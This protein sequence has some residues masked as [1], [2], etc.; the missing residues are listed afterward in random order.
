MEIKSDI[1]GV[2]IFLVLLEVIEFLPKGPRALKY[3]LAIS[4]VLGEWIFDAAKTKALKTTGRRSYA[5]IRGDAG[6]NLVNSAA[7]LKNRSCILAK[8]MNNC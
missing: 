6:R 8:E 7:P 4:E 1:S 2:N 5:A 3:R